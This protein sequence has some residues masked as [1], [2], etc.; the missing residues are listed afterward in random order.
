MVTVTTRKIGKNTYYYLRHNTGSRQAEEYLG[1]KIPPD[2]EQRKERFVLDFYRKEW[3]PKIEA[4][5]KGFVENNKK[6]PKS[7]I[8]EQLNE[9]SI[10]FTYHTNRIE[11]S[12]L[13]LQNTFDLI[14]R[15]LT[16]DKKTSIRYHRNTVAQKGVP[17]YHTKQKANDIF[18]HTKLAQGNLRSDKTRICRNVE[19][20]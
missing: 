9:F 6:M 16:P 7:M 18:H 15:G 2:V 11:G 19:K 4:I 10:V 1:K 8:E 13:T 12:T 5:K 14:K 3:I 20:A 17:R